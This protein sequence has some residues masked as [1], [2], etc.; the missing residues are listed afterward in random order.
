MR[1]AWTHKLQLSGTTVI[2]HTVVNVAWVHRE[3]GFS[4]ISQGGEV[5]LA[6]KMDYAI[7]LIVIFHLTQKGIKG[8]VVTPGMLDY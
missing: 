4:N 8:M 3:L 2:P 1:Y 6:R 5:V 7:H